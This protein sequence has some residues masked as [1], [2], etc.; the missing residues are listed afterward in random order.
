MRKLFVAAQ[1]IVVLAFVST[2]VY[3]LVRPEPVPEHAPQTWKSWRGFFTL[4]YLGVADDDDPRHVSPD[5]L[6]EQLKAIREAGYLTITPDDA[7]AFLDGRAPLP[8]RALLLLFEGGRK[9]SF[10]R[11][12]PILRKTGQIATLCVPTELTDRFGAFYLDRHDLQRI[13]GMAHW[14]LCSMGHD[15]LAPITINAQ[16]ATGHFLTRH[17]WL[18]RGSE[19][20]EEFRARIEHDYERAAHILEGAVDGPVA[21]YVYPY[22]DWLAIPASESSVARFNRRAVAAH[23]RIAFAGVGDAFTGF[24]A[25]PYSLDRLRVRGD[26][27]GA[28]LVRELDSFAP[29]DTAVTSVTASDAWILG[30]GASVD[31]SVLR[32]APDSLAWIRGSDAWSDTDLA[33]TVTLDDGES[34]AALYARHNGP[35]SYVRIA[36]TADGA[37]V[38]ERVAGE[39]RSLARLA[40]SIPA[41]QVHSL[42][43]R[44]KGKRAWAWLDGAA[45]GGPLPLAAFTHQG[46]SGAGSRRGGASISKIDARPVP[47]NFVF[48][49]AWSA[50]NATARENAVAVLVPWS[51][52]PSPDRQRDVLQA[53]AAGVETIPLLQVPA[54]V[55]ADELAA[56]T[57]ATLEGP[58][59][60]RLVTRV[61]LRGAGTGVTETFRNQ[62]YGIVRIAS[63]SEALDLAADG[64]LAPNDLLLLEGPSQEIV[65][66]LGKLLYHVPATH[67]IAATDAVTPLPSW[68][69]RAVHLPGGTP[70]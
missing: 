9:D 20:T 47:A 67:I 32:L 44:V 61:A 31:G 3:L 28:Q 43:L 17:R 6:E 37:Q 46:R 10:L 62:G 56:R 5:R 45:V 58:V 57:A 49:P 51:L 55:D 29:R 1:W 40:M 59:L 63:P 70:P 69:R 27:T 21:A 11:A 38:Q 19:S 65:D 41:G 4:S 68:T 30:A 24:G 12:T 50:L 53:A 35:G 36:L 52:E 34:I 39:T 18:D 54:Q 66:A 15:S 33:A 60:S 23:H 25:D 13:A 42:R 7:A 8:D 16:G 14:R 22:A 2:A 26:W 64:A 48:A